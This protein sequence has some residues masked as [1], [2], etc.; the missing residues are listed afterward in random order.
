MSNFWTVSLFWALFLVF[1]GVA[2]AFILPPLLRREAKPKQVDSKDANVAIYHDQLSELKSDLDN[3]E[4]DRAQYEDARR[5]IE[6]RLSEDVPPQSA[7]V[8]P[9]Q[10][11]RWTGWTLAGMVPVLSVALYMILGNPDALSL[12]TAPEAAVAQGEHDPA[13]MIAALEAKLQAN[14]DNPQGW[15]MLA[16]S[17]AATGRYDD[18]VRVY[19]KASE[20]IPDDSHLLADY[21]DM[22][23]MTQNGNLQGKPLELI[24]KA[25]KL[26]EQD[27]KA[28]NLAGSAAYQAKDFPKAAAYW[29]R[30]L[31]LLPAGDDSAQ[32]VKAVIEETEKMAGSFSG[33]DNLGEKAQAT[34]KIEPATKGVT[35][36]SGTVTVSKEFIAKITP[37]DSVFIFA[38]AP[39]GPKMP[40]ASLKINAAQLPYHFTLDDSMSLMSNNKLASHPEVLISARI[41]KSGEAMPHSGDL[42]GTAGTVKLGKQDVAIV[43]D[44]VLP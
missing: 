4:L 35:A 10:T 43:I 26:N 18:A 24:N 7:T 27:E 32:E 20:L 2:L 39:Q 44:R 15:T 5:E 40:I 3:G 8:A 31:K 1:I 16:R 6:Q 12:S 23:A 28:L 37:G 13:P 21:A 41:S 42:Q 25:L 22:L 29:R 19:A 36:I 30:L 17:Y 9:L 38:Q 11:V 14:P 33:L 34:E